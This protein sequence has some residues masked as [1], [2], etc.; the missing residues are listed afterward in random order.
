MK[1]TCKTESVKKRLHQM[2]KLEK[3]DQVYGEPLHSRDACQ[4]VGV[5]GRRGGVCHLWAFGSEI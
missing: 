5:N 1:T 2:I 3:K 4:G